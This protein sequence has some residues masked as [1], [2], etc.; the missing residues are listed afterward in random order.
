MLTARS[1]PCSSPAAHPGSAPRWR[2]PSR[3]EGGT[4]VVLDVHEPQP[5]ASRSSAVD[6]AAAARR[7]GRGA[8]GSPT[9]T[10]A[11]DG[12][13][14][15]RRHR[16]LRR[17][18]RRRRRRVGPG[19]RR[20]PARHGGGGPRRAA[21]PRAHR[22]A[23]S[24]PSPPRSASARSRPRPPTARAS[25]ASSASPAR[26][27]PRRGDRVGVTLLIPGGMQTHFFDERPEQY[28]PARRPAPQPARGGRARGALRAAPAA[29]LRAARA[30]GR[31]RDRAVLA[32]TAPLLV[33][34]A[35][36]GSATCSPPCRRCAR[37]P[38]RSRRTGACSPRRPPLAPLAAL[39]GAL[40]EVV[41]TAP[42]RRCRRRSTTPTSRS[43]S[44]AA[45]R[46]ATRRCSPARPRRLIAF[47]HEAVWPAARPA[48]L[49]RRRAR[50]RALVPAAVGSPASPP[51]R[52]TCGSTCP[53]V[54][55]SRGG[56]TARRWST[57]EP[58]T[59]RAR[60]PADRWAAVA[61]AER[62]AGRRVA[63]TGSA[64]R[65]RR[66]RRRSPRAAGLPDAAVL[67]GRTNLVELAAAVAAA[68]ARRVRRHR[69]RAPRDRARHPVGRPV[70]PDTARGV[71]SAPGS[72]PR[73]AVDRPPRRPARATSRTPACSRSRS[74]RCWPRS[75]ALG[76]AEPHE[77]LDAG[78]RCP[79]AGTRWQ[80]LRHGRSASGTGRTPAGCSRNACATTPVATTSS[81]SA[82]RAAAC[83]SRT[84]SPARST[85]RSTCSW[86]ASSACPATRST[87]SARSRPA[88]SASSTRR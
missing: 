69:R 46:R 74:R 58:P 32:V 13:R 51:T 80:R 36:S 88:A 20:Q 65:A 12:G 30:A 4:P 79:S 56:A 27:R 49:A 81:C 28:K 40:D 71:G 33:A 78:P 14:D 5:T 77:G 45:G 44:T 52:R 35:P 64:G 18:R 83:P 54:P 86:C 50:G 22:A 70:R 21:V 7:R 17:P 1:G 11:L 47:A 76:R 2:P 29:G 6:L 68:G 84:R 41:D 72:P 34:S 9:R 39:A 31:A 66:S 63:I 82:C 61:R 10:A 24:S 23:A 3:A 25:S 87:R 85:R 19:R 48:R 59:R 57:P 8:R 37:W 67:A 15:R 55:R 53:A 38:G 16:R 42:L 26:W 75:P 43:T 62:A 73:R 60:W